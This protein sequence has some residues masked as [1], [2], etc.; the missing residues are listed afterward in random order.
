[1]RNLSEIFVETEDSKDTGFTFLYDRNSILNYIHS[2]CLS[3]FWAFFENRTSSNAEIVSNNPIAPVVR[4]CGTLPSIDEG[5][6][7]VKCYD[8]K[9]RRCNIVSFRFV[10]DGKNYNELFA[11][12]KR[13][14]VAGV[15][16]KNFKYK[17]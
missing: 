6:R 2:E 14:R 5:R 10:V 4:V 9:I 13:L 3:F 7:L 16:G 1:M 12:D 8:G 17:S 11:V 15:L